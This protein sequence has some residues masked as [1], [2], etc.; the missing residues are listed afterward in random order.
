MEDPPGLAEDLAHLWDQNHKVVG[1]LNI[2]IQAHNPH[3][4]KG[5]ELLMEF[6]L[7]DS[8]HHLDSAGGSDTGNVIS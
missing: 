2:N 6:G 4:Q 1:D 8:R 3:S 5:A 7:V